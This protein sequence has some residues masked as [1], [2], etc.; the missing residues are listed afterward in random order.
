MLAI[1]D[2]TEEVFSKKQLENAKKVADDALE[3]KQQF[4]ANMSHEIRTPMNAIVGF[5]KV[6]MKTDLSDKQKEYI[7]AIKTGSDTLVVLIDD[8]LDLAK[9]DAG[10]M[11]FVQK[12]FEL[13]ASI[14]AMLHLFETRMEEKNLEV[15]E[16]FDEKIPVVLLGDSVRLHQIILNLVNNAFKFTAKGKITVSVLLLFDDDEKVIIEFKEIGRAHV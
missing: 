14:S 9:V 6:L 7:A 15:L 1:E 11:T 2:I 13:R 8:I 5:T 4:L 10:K 16:V 3:S 12:P